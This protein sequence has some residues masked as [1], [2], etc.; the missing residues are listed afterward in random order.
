MPRG[1]EVHPVEEAIVMDMF[2]VDDP[3]DD[4]GR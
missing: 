2:I 1:V 4:R 3:A